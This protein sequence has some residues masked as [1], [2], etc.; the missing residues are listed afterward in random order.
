MLFK[1]TVADGA[2]WMDW[3]GGI[4]G[5]IL[6]SNRQQER[7]HRELLGALDAQLLPEAAP[8]RNAFH[9]SAVELTRLALEFEALPGAHHHTSSWTLDRLV[10]R[11]LRITPAECEALETAWQAIDDENEALDLLDRRQLDPLFYVVTAHNEGRLSDEEDERATELHFAASQLAGR[12]QFAALWTAGL[13]DAYPDAVTAIDNAAAALLLG[14]LI[15]PAEFDLILAPWREVLG[16]RAFAT[17]AAA[18][19]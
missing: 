16:D 19:R 7:R 9:R 5:G 8:D 10:T 18:S 6:W 15:P 12:A 14:T 11:A 13:H 1:A 3:L 17:A 4:L 2:I